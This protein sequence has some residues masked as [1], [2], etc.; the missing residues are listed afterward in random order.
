MAGPLNLSE[1][2]AL[3]RQLVSFDPELAD[4]VA[5]LLRTHA[6]VL[7]RA[8][9]IGRLDERERARHYRTLAEMI[10]RERAVR[11]IRREQPSSS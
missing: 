10:G 4:E 1:I 6:D 9:A 7:E 3:A 5:D 2:S 11:P 8:G